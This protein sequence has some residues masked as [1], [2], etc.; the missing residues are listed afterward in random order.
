MTTP[1]APTAPAPHLVRWLI[2]LH[3]PA[4][5]VGTAFVVVLGA[6][7]LWLWGPLTDGAVTAWRRYDACATVGSC[8]YGQYAILLYK[9]VYQYATF[10]LLAVPFLVA[11][12]AGASLVGRELEQ[13]TARL[14]WTQGVSPQR[15][16]AAKLA[17]PAVPVALGTGLL[18]L[19]HHLMWSAG[20]GRIGTAKDWYSGETF[21]ANGTVPVAL[22]LAG[23]AAGALLGLLTGRSLAALGGALGFTGLLWLGTQ[24]LMPH[25]WPTVTRV[26]SLRDGPRG[27]G[28]GV[29]RGLLTSSGARVGDQGCVDGATPQC[30]ALFDNLDAVGRYHDYHPESHYWPLQFTT[31]AVLLGGTA[32]LTVAA[33]R[34]LRRRTT[35]PTAVPASAPTPAPA[36]E[37][38]TV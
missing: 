29:E 22:A 1:T 12:W 4:L 25:L 34:V 8:S 9:D 36:V 31:S 5:L 23:L 7:L 17:V 14:A 19:L 37:K 6:T 30:R 20:D 21:Y 3:R 32:L 13:G 16:L 18:V 10:A 24:L 38:A 33:F 11:A 15:W 26:S 27:S 2:R 28:L 35:G